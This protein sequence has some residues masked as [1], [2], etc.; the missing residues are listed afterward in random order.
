MVGFDRLTFGRKAGCHFAISSPAMRGVAAAIIMALAGCAGEEAP[1]A[2]APVGAPPAPLV[3]DKPTAPDASRFLMQATFGPT[4]ADIDELVSLGYSDWIRRQFNAPSE[5]NVS[6]VRQLQADYAARGAT[7]GD[8]ALADLA[9]RDMI[10]GEDQLRQRMIF[11]LS[12]IFVVSYESSD[13]AETL[14]SAAFYMDML[15][16]NAFGNYR[17]LIE[18]VTYSPSMAQYLTYLN[19]RKEDPAQ[20]RVPDE[21]YA[22]ELMQLFTIGLVEL[23][24]D[25]SP[26][27]DGSGNTIETYTNDDITGLAKVFTGLSWD[28][29]NFGGRFPDQSVPVAAYSPLVVFE[30]EH[31]TSEKVFLG[32]TVAANTPAAQSIDIALDTLFNHANTAPF[33][34]RQMIQRFVT[35]NPSSQYVRNVAAA[36]ETGWYQLPDGSTIGSLQRGDMQAVIAAVLLDDE[37]RL[38]PAL[39]NPNFG[40]V[41]E[42]VI[43]FTH[44]ARVADLNSASVLDQGTLN[45]QS[46]L[47]ET[48]P[49]TRLGQQ[50]YRS[51]SVFNFFRPG[52]V[53]AGTETGELGLVAPELQ[54]VTT[55]SVTAYANFMMSRI[56]EA[57]A[58]ETY[59]PGY[60][61]ELS[62]ADNPAALVDHLNLVM[63]AGAMQPSTR[64]AIVTAVTGVPLRAGSEPQDRR[65]RVNA[66]MLMT[67]LS[68]EYYTQR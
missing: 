58:L 39:A 22:R 44:W 66:A 9:W 55:A 51:P 29:G 7:V 32:V 16:K 25:G 48:A 20:N 31:S 6:E 61:R 57:D 8:E 24:P 15:D 33:F 64:D 2:V 18:D 30:Q 63:T 10:D 38:A 13:V 28:D 46:D 27:V 56:E 14:S 21:N 12:Q 41:R 4:Q 3:T 5:L 26:R 52:Y 67:V 36:F 23:N 37:A 53:A 60:S 1:S 59:R 62:L 40:K 42:P 19:N 68:S 50:A 35:S 43:R 49:P 34:A 47:E 45:G 11:A 65:R 54:I 17:T